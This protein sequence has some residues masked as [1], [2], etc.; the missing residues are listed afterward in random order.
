M[1]LLFSVIW[2]TRSDML[3]TG[4]RQR[5]SVDICDLSQWSI[6]SKCGNTSIDRINGLGDCFFKKREKNLN[7][8]D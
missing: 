4:L 7:V 3:R 8:V 5:K 1:Y 2:K 6:E